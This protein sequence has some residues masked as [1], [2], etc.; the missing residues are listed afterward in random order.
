MRAIKFRA[1]DKEKK[2]MIDDVLICSSGVWDSE[3]MWVDEEKYK[4]MQYTGLKDRNGK[5]IYEGDICKSF[6]DGHYI[7]APMIWNEN[8]AQF[9]LEAIVDFE[10]E[11]HVEVNVHSDEDAPEVIGN[12]YENPELLK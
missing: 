12:I 7:I 1:W 4:P 3:F 6:I 2:K 5:E 11:D 8:K 9:G 10:S